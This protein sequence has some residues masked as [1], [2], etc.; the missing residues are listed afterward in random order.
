MGD[1]PEQSQPAEIVGVVANTTNVGT[2]SAPLPE[3][4]VPMEQG[5]D[6]WN[7]LFLVAKIAGDP[8]SAVPAIRQAVVSIDPDQPVY[9]IQ[10]LEQA[11]E[12]SI[13]PQQ[14]STVLLTIFAVVALV[15]AGIGIYGVTS[16][17]VR[18]RTQEIGIR[19]AMGAERR[20]VMWMVLRQVLMLVAAGLTIGIGGVLA[21]GPALSAVLFGVSAVDPLTVAANGHRPGRGCTRRRVVAGVSREP[22]RSGRGAAVRVSGGRRTRII[23]A[24]NSRPPATPDRRSHRASGNS[25]AMATTMAISER[26]G[27]PATFTAPKLIVTGGNDSVMSPPIYGRSLPLLL[28]RPDSVSRCCC[29]AAAPS[30]PPMPIDSTALL[31]ISIS[32]PFSFSPS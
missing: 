25:K 26:P 27:P 1:K 11:F 5:R 30:M 16:Y 24:A 2:A 18:S 4:F 31:G 13:L 23:A 12:T 19:M 3:V 22:R 7:Q 32:A 21:L 8:M 10:T 28:L 15:L 9:A 14:V 17:A 29:S 6:T 20:S